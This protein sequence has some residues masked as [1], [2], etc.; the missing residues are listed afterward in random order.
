MLENI[1]DSSQL[2]FHYRRWNDASVKKIIQNATVQKS[3]SKTILSY[4]SR[5]RRCRPVYDL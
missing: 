3:N 1:L 5:S 4:S 2:R